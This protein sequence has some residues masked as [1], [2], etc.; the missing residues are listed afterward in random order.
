MRATGKKKAISAAGIT[1]RILTAAAAVLL[2][3]TV[4][5]SVWAPGVYAVSR[6]TLSVETDARSAGTAEIGVVGEL[7]SAV[8]AVF[9]RRR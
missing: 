3:M 2:T 9:H 6:V 7:G 8:G 5:L 1:G 4:L